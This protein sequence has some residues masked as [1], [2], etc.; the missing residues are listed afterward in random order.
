MMK[1]ISGG[2]IQE[3]SNNVTELNSMVSWIFYQTIT[4]IMLVENMGIL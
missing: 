3:P 4:F 2:G 1:K